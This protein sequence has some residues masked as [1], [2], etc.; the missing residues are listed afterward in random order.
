M[1][2]ADVKKL[3]QDLLE[4]M[5]VGFDAIGIVEEPVSKRITFVIET[6]QPELL[7][8]EDGETFQALSHV[9]KRIAGKGPEAFDFS[10]DV[11]DYRSSVAEKLKIKAGMLANRVRDMK[12]DVEMEPMSS[13][14]RLIVHGALA[15]EPN[16]KTESV[17]VGK[18]RRIVI[19]YIGSIV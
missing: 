9:I 15:G 18:D 6:K 8:G 19:K 7:I 12:A 17:G 4:H 3:I 13:Y 14:E 10:I 11:N 16:I 1:K 5:A 2:Q